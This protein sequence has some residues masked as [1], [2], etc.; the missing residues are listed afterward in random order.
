M[1]RPEPLGIGS[2]MAKRALAPSGWRSWRRSEALIVV[3]GAL[4]ALDLLV[5][6]WH[7]YFVDVPTGNLGLNL[8]TFSYD[9]TAVQSPYNGFGIAAL[10][11]ALAMAVYTLVAKV[12]PVVR[13]LEQVHLVAGPTVLG[14]LLAKMLVDN[15]FLGTGSYLGVLLGAGVALGGFLLGREAP[16]GSTHTASPP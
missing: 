11:I 8:P 6:P 10:V 3:C 13:R 2:G 14:L 15:A 16:A 9:R 4:L 1:I 5:L 12:S 7:H